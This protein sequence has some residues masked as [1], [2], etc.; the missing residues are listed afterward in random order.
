MTEQ[1]A[2]NL[3][4]VLEFLEAVDEHLGDSSPITLLFGGGVAMMTVVPG[5]V[6]VAA[7]VLDRTIHDDLMAAVA[8]VAERESLT[9]GWLNN[10]AARFVPTLNRAPRSVLFEGT[11]LAIRRGT[12]DAI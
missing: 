9:A 10:N 4:R 3:D 5:R 2:L 12:F 8:V 11:R 6:S 7:D 1:Q